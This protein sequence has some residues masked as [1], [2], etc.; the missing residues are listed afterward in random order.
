MITQ[1][2]AYIYQITHGCLCHGDA[3]K[4]LQRDWSWVPRS[5][6][7]CG[8]GDVID[9]ELDFNSLELGYR[10]NGKHLGTAFQVENTSYRAGIAAYSAGDVIELV[11]YT[12][13]TGVVH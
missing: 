8:S 11:S 1:G 13:L 6:Y 7:E 3:G 5:D 9:M 12:C 10:A 2:K 4:G